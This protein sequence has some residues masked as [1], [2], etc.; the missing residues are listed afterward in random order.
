M[1][2]PM[3]SSYNLKRPWQVKNNAIQILQLASPKS[4]DIDYML[5]LILLGNQIWEVYGSTFDLDWP[6]KVL[7][8]FEGLPLE[9]E[10]SWAICY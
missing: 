9:N 8:K 2:S 4:A 3:A 1:G 5:L 10:P 7:G 6:R